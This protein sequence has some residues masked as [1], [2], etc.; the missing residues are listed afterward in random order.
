[1]D[2]RTDRQRYTCA[3]NNAHGGREREGGRGRQRMR[4]RERDR[5]TGRQAGSQ[6]GRKTDRQTD[7]QTVTTDSDRQTNRTGPDRTG[8]DRTDRRHK[9]THT[10]THK[11]KKHTHTQ[12]HNQPRKQASKQTRKHTRSNT[13][14][15]RRR[16]AQTRMTHTASPASP[17]TCRLSEVF[18]SVGLCRL[19]HVGRGALQPACCG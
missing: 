4:E 5:Q 13:Q 17:N 12:T 2:A 7:K 1:M 3:I 18:L 9:H 15:K 16:H 19:E 11:K 10:H 6:A 8:Q 14:R